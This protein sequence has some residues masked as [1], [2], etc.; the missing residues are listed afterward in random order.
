MIDFGGRRSRSYGN[1]LVCTIETKSL[2]ASSSNLADIN[3]VESMILI[4]F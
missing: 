2:W 1:K 4:D 3:N